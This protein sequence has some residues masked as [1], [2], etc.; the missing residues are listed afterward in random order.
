MAHAEVV[1]HLFRYICYLPIFLAQRNRHEER[2]LDARGGGDQQQQQ[3]GAA[4][5]HERQLGGCAGAAEPAG[6]GHVRP[7]AEPAP[8]GPEHHR[9]AGLAQQGHGATPGHSSFIPL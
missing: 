5:E 1:L 6:R 9:Q 2:R 8:P 4:A 3:L 7:E